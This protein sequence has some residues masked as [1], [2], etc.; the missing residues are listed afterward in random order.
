MKS[1]LW[2]A[3]GLV[4]GGVVGFA[5]YN[6]KID[7]GAFLCGPGD[8]CPSGFTCKAGRC[9]DQGEPPPDASVPTP[10]GGCWGPLPNCSMPTAPLIGACDPVC[11]TMCKCNERCT[12]GSGTFQ[13]RA[14]TAPPR[15]PYETCDPSADAC[16]AGTVCLDEATSACGAHCYKFCRNDMDCPGNQGRCTGVIVVGGNMTQGIC[17]PPIEPLCNPTGLRPAC[18]PR[19]N[20]NF[21]EFACYIATQRAADE[22]IC[23]CAGTKAEG[24]RCETEHE[25]RPGLECVRI[26]TEALCRQ[27]CTPTGSPVVPAV[28]CR[29]GTCTKFQTGTRF[30]Y[31][32]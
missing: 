21:P 8:A 2:L 7:E 11:Q 19:A 3:G 16:R 22:T 13:C 25:C 4:V 12:Y 15:A 27:L 17:G 28:P 24:V 29:V 26:G 14:V 18:P 32:L 6:P 30:G 20:R 10:D 31:C 5:C 23:E 1:L 9:Y